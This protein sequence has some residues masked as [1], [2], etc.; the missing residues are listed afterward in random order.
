[1]F[2]R[3]ASAAGAVGASAAAV[4]LP[5]TAHAAVHATTGPAQVPEHD[6]VLA[7][8][9]QHVASDGP[10]AVRVVKESTGSTYTVRPG[11]Y[12]SKIAGEKCGNPADYTGIAQASGVKNPNLIYPDQVLKLACQVV[13]AAF[14]QP[15][16]PVHHYSSDGD[17]DRDGSAS[18]YRSSYQAPAPVHHHYRATVTEASGT[19][20]TA[21][22]SAFQ[23]CVIQRE[24]GGRA[25]AVNPT[26][27]AGGLYQFLPST[28]AA[29]GYS[30]LPED[31]PVSVQNEAFAKEYAAGGTSAWGPYDGC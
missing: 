9:V 21:G 23:A 18:D 30:G 16:A 1:M 12:L 5:G 27:G 7:A 2:K 17:E 22:M 14:T 6:P 24:S 28:W 29:L 10:K 3:F 20:S 25:D 4:V 26:S 13:T 31:A 8:K 19:V 11:D 15:A